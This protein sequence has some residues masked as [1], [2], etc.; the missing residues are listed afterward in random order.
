MIKKNDKILGKFQNLAITFCGILFLLEV[1]VVVTMS[2][3]PDNGAAGWLTYVYA[4]FGLLIAV[5]YHV[6]GVRLW[7]YSRKIM[8]RSRVKKN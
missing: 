4:G 6:A 8:V 5:F 3:I 7:L 2:I 1:S